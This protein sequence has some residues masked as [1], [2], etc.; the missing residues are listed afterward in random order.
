MVTVTVESN[1]FL[2]HMVRVIAGTLLEV[3][4]GR[5]EPERVAEV[6]RT[7]DRRAAGPTA[8]AQGLML[9]AVRYD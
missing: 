2:Y 7:R 6:L 4:R 8:A 9:V 1:R 5:M 3:G